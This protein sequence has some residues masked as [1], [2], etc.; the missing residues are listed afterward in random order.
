[1]NPKQTAN[2][3]EE[4]D[5]LKLQLAIE[6][7][8]GAELQFALAQKQAQETAQER[9]AEQNRIA[10][11]YG[12]AQQDQIDLA[13]GEIKRVAAAPKLAAV[14]PPPAEPAPAPAAQE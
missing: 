9:T 7:Q 11:E 6:R 14:P 3:L 4:L 13:T 5:R 12:L 2:K 10:A 1:M 8:R